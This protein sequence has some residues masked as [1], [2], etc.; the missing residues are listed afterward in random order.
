MLPDRVSLVTASNI[1]NGTK[2]VAKLYTMKNSQHAFSHLAQHLASI[3]SFAPQQ[4]SKTDNITK[5]ISEL[6]KLR[7]NK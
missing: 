1:G 2:N 3:I 4:A 6:R 5:L 7:E